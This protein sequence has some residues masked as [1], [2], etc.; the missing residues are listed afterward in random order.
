MNSN[1]ELDPITIEVIRNNLNS[2]AAQMKSTLSRASFNVAVYEMLDFSVGIFNRQGELL[3]EGTGMPIFTGTLS[4]AIKNIVNYIG[5]KELEPGDVILSTFPYWTGGHAMDAAIIMPIFIDEELFAYAAA[6]AHWMDIGATAVFALSTTDIWQEGL[7]LY[8]VKIRKK[9]L[10]DNELIEIIRANS[11][12]P[13]DVIGDLMA[14]MACCDVAEKNIVQLVGKYGQGTVQRATKMIL[15]HGENL[16][17]MIIRE[18]PDG[19]WFAEGTIDDNGVEDSLVKVQLTVTV[20]GDEMVMDTTGSAPQQRG[21]INCPLPSTASIGRM[22]FKMLTTPDYPNNEGFFRPLKVTAPEGSIFN[23]QPPAPVMVYGTSSSVLAE[24]VNKALAEVL[25]EKVV[26]GSG[27]ELSAS[28]IHGINPKD[29]SFFAG[30]TVDGVGQGASI[31]SDGESALIFYTN[32][33]CQNVPVEILEERFPLLIEKYG[34]RQDS[35]GPGRFRGGLGIERS[36][37]ARDDLSL[38]SIMQHQQS[39]PWG[40]YGGENGLPNIGVV[41]PGTPKEQ[42]YGKIDSE[43]ILAGES[44]HVLAGGG[45]GWGNPHDRALED[46]LRD[47]V[48]GYVSLTGALESYGVVIEKSGDKYVL[49]KA[50]SQKLRQRHSDGPGKNI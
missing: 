48:Q 10:V 43:K 8:G 12:L 9:G 23:P 24:L 26:A 30:G 5:E 46:V 4:F 47:V 27:C 28:L 20:Q 15:D 39:P 19:Q 2:T 7:Q 6:K 44:W 25:P 35:G 41:N 18:I 1:V 33:D 49:D 16:A 34:L 32:G 14:Q 42:Q 40:L 3:A 17:R 11:R 21:P 45:G 22:M 29:G 31:D 37:K 38:I 13:D 50:E 36:W